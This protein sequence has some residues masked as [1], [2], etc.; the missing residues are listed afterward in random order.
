MR[1]TALIVFFAL[2]ACNDEPDFDERYS[3]AASEIRATADDIDK[4]LGTRKAAEN[5]GAPPAVSDQKEE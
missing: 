1:R 3:Q 4:E 5:P 2:S